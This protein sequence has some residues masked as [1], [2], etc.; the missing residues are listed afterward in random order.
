MRRDAGGGTDAR[1]AEAGSRGWGAR[2]QGAAVWRRAEPGIQT[3]TGWAGGH[4]SGRASVAWSGESV[5]GSPGKT[6]V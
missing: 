1:P 6:K 2:G 3:E 5:R 4:P